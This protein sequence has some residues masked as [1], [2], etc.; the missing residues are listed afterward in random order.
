ME[1]GGFEEWMQHSDHVPLVVTFEGVR[2]DRPWNYEGA[3][4][5]QRVIAAHCK[6]DGEVKMGTM[7]G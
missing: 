1:I 3:A 6:H 2:G 7:G 4:K 5:A